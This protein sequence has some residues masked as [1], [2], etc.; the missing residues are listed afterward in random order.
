MNTYFLWAFLPSIGSCRALEWIPLIFHWLSLFFFLE[1]YLEKKI[2]Y[3]SWFFRRRNVVSC[4]V[5]S[6]L[7]EDANFAF[8]EWK[9]LG[10]EW[11]R[12]LITVFL[13]EYLP[14]PGESVW[15]LTSLFP[16]KLTICLS[17]LSK[18]LLK[19]AFYKDRMLPVLVLPFFLGY[20][21]GTCRWQ[22]KV[23]F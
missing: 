8:G 5:R 15:H 20:F 6:D 12:G 2:P 18:S 23:L 16:L 10:R 1:N 22:L 21:L 4:R 17:W 3:P 7:V 11:R 14:G 9:L 13:L 19:K